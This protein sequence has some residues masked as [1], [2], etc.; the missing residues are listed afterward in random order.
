MPNIKDVISIHNNQIKNQNYTSTKLDNCN[1]NKPSECPLNKNC[2]TE[3]IIYM[4]KA[5]VT[6]PDDGVTQKST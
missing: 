2:K 4:Y 3:N 1:C 5:Q 6:S